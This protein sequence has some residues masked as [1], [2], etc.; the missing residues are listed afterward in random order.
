MYEGGRQTL[1]GLG[2]MAP[3]V[4]ALHCCGDSGNLIS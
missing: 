1:E 4:H 2:E 3:E